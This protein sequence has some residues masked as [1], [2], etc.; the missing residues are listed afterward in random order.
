MSDKK[1]AA[2]TD[3]VD[4]LVCE[5]F[6]AKPLMEYALVLEWAVIATE[7]LAERQTDRQRAPHFTE[8]VEAMDE[9]AT[10]VFGDPTV[11][12][13]RTTESTLADAMEDADRHTEWNGKRISGEEVIPPADLWNLLRAILD[14]RMRKLP[15]EYRDAAQAKT[16][17]RIGRLGRD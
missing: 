13:R 17:K 4:S 16:E 12:G 15:P 2:G 8:I 11:T 1:G 14:E 10:K 6:A 5:V 7:T 9:A 3:F